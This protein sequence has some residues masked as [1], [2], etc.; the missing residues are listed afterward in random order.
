MYVEVMFFV[1]CCRRVTDHAV[2]CSLVVN[3]FIDIKKSSKFIKR[4]EIVEMCRRWSYGC[5]LLKSTSVS[6]NWDKQA[7]NA[8]AQVR[9]Q[10]LTAAERSMKFPSVL[11]HCFLLAYQ[12]ARALHLHLPLQKLLFSAMKNRISLLNQEKTSWKLQYEA[13]NH[14]EDRW[15]SL[16]EFDK[17]TKSKTILMANS[18]TGVDA[19]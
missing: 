12:G 4:L 19:N 18:H 11:S 13:S 10:L 15:S 17:V 6:E 1:F 7:K 8:A 9:Q 2:C 14:S 3:V 5:D 16:P